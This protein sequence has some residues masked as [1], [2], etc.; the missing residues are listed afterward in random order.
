MYVGTRN[1]FARGT[2]V[3][4]HVSVGHGALLKG[5]VIGDRVL[6][7]M[8]AVIDDGAVVRMHMRVTHRAPRA[9]IA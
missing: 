2:V 5:C 3:G 8:G 4:T 7:G 6:I 9:P 1:V